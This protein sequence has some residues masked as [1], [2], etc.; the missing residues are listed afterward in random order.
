MDI[1]IASLTLA[2]TAAVVSFVLYLLAS[3][4][5]REME[6]RQRMTYRGWRF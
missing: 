5:I 2:L 6:A 4:R 3:R 1:Y